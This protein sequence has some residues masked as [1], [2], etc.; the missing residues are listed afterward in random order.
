MKLIIVT[1]QNDF[2]ENIERLPHLASV[3]FADKPH[4]VAEIEL[5]LVNVVCKSEINYD[6]NNVV[7]ASCMGIISVI[8]KFKSFSNRLIQVESMDRFK[9]IIAMELGIASQV[10]KE[11]NSKVVCLTKI[12]D[13]IDCIEPHS[14][15]YDFQLIRPSELSTP[16]V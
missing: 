12:Q 13:V 4:D 16:S 8:N 7:L 2:T 3:L 1:T 10:A 6:Q 5:S 15:E 9:M 14:E 11:G